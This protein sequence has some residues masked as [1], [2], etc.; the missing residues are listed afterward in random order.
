MSQLSALKKDM[1]N[2]NTPLSNTS[3]EF[4]KPPINDFYLADTHLAKRY[5][6]SRQT[7]WRWAASDET[8]PSPIKLSP[9][10]TRW[11]LSDLELWEAAK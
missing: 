5:K 10:C 11:K 3:H 6:V 9:G 1:T 7:I 2:M 4:N 8:F